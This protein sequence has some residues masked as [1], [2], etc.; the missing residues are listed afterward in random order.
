VWPLCLLNL[1]N[2]PTPETNKLSIYWCHSAENWS[3]HWKSCGWVSLQS[4]QLIRSILHS[5]TLLLGTGM[6]SGLQCSWV[7]CL[8]DCSSAGVVQVSFISQP[9]HCEM[10]PAFG[11]FSF[12]CS[13]PSWP[14]CVL[15]HRYV[16]NFQICISR[17]LNFRLTSHILLDK[18]V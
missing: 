7:Y 9:L 8:A 5:W 1:W 10:S 16:D 13:F 4:A 11:L 18:F 14:Q 15:Y 17:S 6:K 2:S 3:L 12:L